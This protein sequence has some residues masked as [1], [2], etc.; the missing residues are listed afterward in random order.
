MPIDGETAKEE[1]WLWLTY[2]ILIYVFLVHPPPRSTPPSPPIPTYPIGVQQH[3]TRPPPGEMA[4]VAY[5]LSIILGRNILS[6]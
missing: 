6:G 1:L 2:E 4:K 3:N 5:L